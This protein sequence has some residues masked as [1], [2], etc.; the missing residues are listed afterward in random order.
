[1]IDAILENGAAGDVRR[2]ATT[3][4]ETARTRMTARTET[5]RTE[6]TDETGTVTTETTDESGT[7]MIVAVLTVSLKNRR[8]KMC[9]RT[10]MIDVILENGANADVRRIATTTTGTVTT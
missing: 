3:T 9:L 5:Q 6:M 10:L 7:A 8:R 2:I 4:T 1:M